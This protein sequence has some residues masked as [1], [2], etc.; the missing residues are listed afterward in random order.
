MPTAPD[1]RLFCTL[2]R[3]EDGYGPHLGC[4]LKA[5]A[6]YPRLSRLTERL[7]MV[8]GIAETIRRDHIRAHFAARA[9]QLG[10]D[11]GTR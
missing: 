10:L 7:L 8:P 3:L 1:W 9:A 2:V 5:L 6:D 11:W 4:D